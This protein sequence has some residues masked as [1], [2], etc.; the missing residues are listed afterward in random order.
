LKRGYLGLFESVYLAGRSRGFEES[1]EKAGL[2]IPSSNIPLDKMIYVA[3]F[4]GGV[5]EFVTP[6]KFNEGSSVDKFISGKIIEPAQQTSEFL[7]QMISVFSEYSSKEEDKSSVMIMS[8]VCDLIAGMQN[9]SSIIN[10]SG[11]PKISEVKESLPP[12]LSMPICH[13]LSQL[14]TTDEL[15]PAPSLNID[16]DSVTRFKEILD[17]NLYSQYSSAHK[18]LECANLS[19]KKVLANVRDKGENILAKGSNALKMRRVSMNVMPV[20]PK[21]VDAAFGKLPGIL[22][23]M[24]GDLATK[25][26]QNNKNIVVYQ[27]QDWSDEYTNS[28]L[29]YLR[30]QGESKS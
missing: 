11:I 13:L 19:N 18:E 29:A 14:I 22:A 7:K 15:L 9:D 27:F 5:Q 26:M 17:S 21:I 2:S 6:M 28:T 10:V 23:Q 3:A 30:S 24:A 4:Q 16:S 8:F 12:E 25:S 1:S 20:L